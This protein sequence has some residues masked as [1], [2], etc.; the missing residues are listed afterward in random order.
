MPI[1]YH[2]L[3]QLLTLGGGSA[4]I[5]CSHT[6]DQRPSERK[7]GRKKVHE[8][9]RW[10]LATLTIPLKIEGLLVPAVWR[11]EILCGV[12][13]RDGEYTEDADHQ[14]QSL[15]SVFNRLFH[16]L[17]RAG[18]NIV[19]GSMLIPINGVFDFPEDALYTESE[20]DEDA[21]TPPDSDSGRQQS[22]CE[23]DTHAQGSDGS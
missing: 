9:C 11:T 2:S 1:Y 6:V 23:D 4:P 8:T 17:E 5:V 15:Q 3:N 7:E 12:K 16:T 18:H 10:F 22:G 20:E 13:E 14:L 21:E 19:R